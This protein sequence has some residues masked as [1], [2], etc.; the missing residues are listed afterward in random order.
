M[1]QLKENKYVQNVT[2]KSISYTM[3]FKELF[4]EETKKSKGPT[5][6]FIEAG[7]NPFILGGDRIRGFSKSIKKKVKNGLPLDDNRGKKSKGRL[8][9]EK[10][11]LTKD[12]EIELLKHE[13]LMLKAENDLLKKME[14]LVNQRQLKKS[15]QQK[16]IN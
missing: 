5:R 6:I 1:K 11:E 12:E 9:K 15:Q 13:N 3:E 2:T 10:K 4:I 8:K 14:F 16:D 7:F